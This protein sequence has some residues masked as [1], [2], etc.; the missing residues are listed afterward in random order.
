MESGF[1]T[2]FDTESKNDMQSR[3]CMRKADVPSKQS[4]I[5]G[6]RYLCEKKARRDKSGFFLSP[7]VS[8]G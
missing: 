6:I 8:Q 5:K 2:D 1:F 7:L 4:L 3:Y